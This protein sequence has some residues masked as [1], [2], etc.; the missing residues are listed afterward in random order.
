MRKDTDSKLKFKTLQADLGASKWQVVGLL[1]TLWHFTALNAPRGDL[2]R[3]S[4]RQIAVGI[5]YEPTAFCEGTLGGPVTIDELIGTLV[6][7]GWIDEHA[8][9]AVRLVVHDWAEHCEQWVKKAV[10]RSKSDFI[11]ADTVRQ[12]ADNGGQCPPSGGQRRTLSDPLTQTGSSVRLEVFNSGNCPA[13]EP[14]RAEPSRAQPSRAD[15]T[16][17]DDRETSQATCENLDGSDRV[18]SQNEEYSDRVGASRTAGTWIAKFAFDAA[19]A[20]GLSPERAVAERR[21]L[22]AVGR[23]LID[24]EDRAEVVEEILG[25]AKRKAEAGLDNP[26]A[27]WNKYLE[28]IGV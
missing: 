14:S 4:N 12:V 21:F 10:R 3:Y 18:D 16:D 6:R 25:E 13:S 28:S 23:R 8:D 1:Q 24:R 2:G 17:E 20:L 15:A 22:R 19:C 9:P 27:A 26:A 7:H 11:A 5:E